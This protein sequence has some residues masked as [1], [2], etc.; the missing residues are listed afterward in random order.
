MC[1][2][3]LWKIAL[4]GPIIYFC[5]SA[6]EALWASTEIVYF[7]L[8][9]T[10]SAGTLVLISRFA[11][12]I[13]SGSEALLIPIGGCIGMVIPL[14][15]GFRHVFPYKE[16][17]NL[18]KLLPTAVHEFLPARGLVQSRHLP[19]LCLAGQCVLG[20]LFPSSFREWPLALVAYFSSWFY[21]RYLMHF[22]YA[23]LRGD[24]SSEFNLSLLFPKVSRPTIDRLS[25]AVFDVAVKLSGGWLDLR[26]TDKVSL[27]SSTT[28]YSPADSAAASAALESMAT[29]SS[30]D[31]A[32]F[33]QRR[34]RAL[35]FLDENIAALVGRT[36]SL[37]DDKGKLVESQHAIGGMTVDEIAEV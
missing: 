14:V 16:L 20:F 22:P 35:K 4:S 17:F 7:I 23:N 30:E 13:L 21:I 11:M 1:E 36:E 12:Y 26:L 27:T 9:S 34:A 15:V 37:T 24:H 5:L 6:L 29:M 28:L 8:F 31:R 10:G 2:T 18:N 33:E 32:K 3:S 25:A 19:F